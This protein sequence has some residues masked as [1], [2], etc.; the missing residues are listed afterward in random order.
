MKTFTRLALLLTLLLPTSTIE[1]CQTETA[2]R[3][4]CTDRCTRD[5][6]TKRLT[7]VWTCEPAG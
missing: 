6:K 3:K 1:R 2:R 7:C 4:V 5:A